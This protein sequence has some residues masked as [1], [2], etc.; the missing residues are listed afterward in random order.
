[1]HT[2]KNFIVLTRII[3]S[4]FTALCCKT[5][6]GKLKHFDEF[7]LTVVHIKS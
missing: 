3:H 2:L 7:F 6:F 1:M 4:Y 5:V